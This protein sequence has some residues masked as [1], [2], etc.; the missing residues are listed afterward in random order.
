MAIEGYQSWSSNPKH[1]M[2]GVLFNIAHLE[3]KNALVVT[4]FQ[5]RKMHLKNAAAIIDQL[6]SVNLDVKGYNLDL[7]EDGLN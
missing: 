5:Q 3:T 6:K 7:S 2:S 4:D 1:E